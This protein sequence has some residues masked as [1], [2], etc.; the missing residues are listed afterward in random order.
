MKTTKS[1]FVVKC[2][3]EFLI[4]DLGGPMLGSYRGDVFIS[5]DRQGS[6]HSY[7][8]VT[9]LLCGRAIENG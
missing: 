2:S 1:T 9:G 8:V 4:S 6:P 7:L 5:S 3:A